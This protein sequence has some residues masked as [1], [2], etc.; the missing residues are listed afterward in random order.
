[1]ARIRKA[2]SVKR[3]K[4]CQACKKSVPKIVGKKK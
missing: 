2:A 3:K 4:A 1:M